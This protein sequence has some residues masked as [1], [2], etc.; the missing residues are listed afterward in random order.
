MPVRKSKG[1][2]RGIPNG[3]QRHKLQSQA[4]TVQRW[5]ANAT[6]PSLSTV[7]QLKSTNGVVALGSRWAQKG[8][9]MTSSLCCGLCL[10]PFM[11]SDDGRF[12]VASLWRRSINAM[13]MA[14][15][16]V[17]CVHK[18]FATILVFTIMPVG[19]IAAVLSYAGF[20][21]QMTTMCAGIGFLFLPSLSCQVLNSWSPTILQAA[22]RLRLAYK[23]PWS[24]ASSSIQVLSTMAAGGVCVSVFP[25]LSFIFPNVPIFLFPSLKASCLVNVRDAWLTELAVKLGCWVFDVGIYAACLALVCFTNQFIVSE[26]GFQKALIDLLR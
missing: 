11:K 16:F 13:I 15:L 26:I 8:F 10:V 9:N 7:G 1:R 21:L 5:D 4:L 6:D 14:L 25:L 22:S 19:T 2:R 24:Y 3:V 20:H 23:S 17:T 18:L 12:R